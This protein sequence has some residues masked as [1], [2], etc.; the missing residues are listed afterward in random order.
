MMENVERAIADS[1]TVQYAP[2]IRKLHR[3]DPTGVT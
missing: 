1:T 2:F 3:T